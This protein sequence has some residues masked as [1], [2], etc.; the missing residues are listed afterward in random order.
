MKLAPNA[1]D[2]TG[3]TYGR[4]TALRPVG[5]APNG[6]IKWLCSCQ[7]GGEKS[8]ATSALIRGATQSC[9]CLVSETAAITLRKIRKRH[10]QKPRSRITFIPRDDLEDF[11]L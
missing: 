11:S 9:G 5:K 7:C 10:G 6:A 8:V 1:L 3:V 2:L 4:L